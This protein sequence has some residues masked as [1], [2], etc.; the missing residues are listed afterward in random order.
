MVEDRTKKLILL[1]MIPFSEQFRELAARVAFGQN[2]VRYSY[3]LRFPTTPGH[4]HATSNTDGTTP[5]VDLELAPR[6]A[7]ARQ[8]HR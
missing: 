2:E 5:V 4:H 6:H 1:R 3:M 7:D 8:P